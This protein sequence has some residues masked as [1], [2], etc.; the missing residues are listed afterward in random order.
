MPQRNRERGKDWHMKG[1][2]WKRMVNMGP[3]KRKERARNNIYRFSVV[4]VF[5]G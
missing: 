5:C 2:L 4:P 1:L 3:W